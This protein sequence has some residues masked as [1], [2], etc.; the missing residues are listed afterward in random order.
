MKEDDACVVACRDNC[1]DR[2]ICNVENRTCRCFYGWD[3]TYCEEPRFCV[4]VM[5]N[6]MERLNVWNVEYDVNDTIDYVFANSPSCYHDC[7]KNEILCSGKY[8]K[9]GMGNDTIACLIDSNCSRVYAFLSNHVTIGGIAM[10]IAMVIT[11]SAILICSLTRKARKRKSS[12]GDAPISMQM[13]NRD[14]ER[15]G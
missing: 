6:G 9:D 3:G 13:R 10:G 15:N 7:L 14:G 4:F 5:E 1:S 2:G 11:G 8:R 12:R